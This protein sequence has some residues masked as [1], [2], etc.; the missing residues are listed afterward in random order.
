MKEIKE[1]DLPINHSFHRGWPIHWSNDGTWRYDDNNE[2]IKCNPEE[3]RP[4]KRCGYPKRGNG[5]DACTGHLPG[6]RYFC[7]GHG[8]QGYIV[9][10]NG[11]I[12]N[13]ENWTPDGRTFYSK[14]DD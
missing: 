3:D 4:C 13:F 5:E 11:K 8:E 9:F 7:C 12:F 1:S 14:E 10:E 2:R 6:V